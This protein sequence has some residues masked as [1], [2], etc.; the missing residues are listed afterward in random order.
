[1]LGVL[2]EGNPAVASILE[3]GCGTGGHAWHLVNAGCSVTGLDLSEHMVAN[4]RARFAAAPEDVRRR[5]RA[6]KADASGFALEEKFDALIS[7]F[8]VA[9]YQTSNDALLGYFRSA[10]GALPDGGLFLFDF[11]HGP[12]V[13]TDRPREV[14]RV[15][16]DGPVT[17]TRRTHPVMR[18]NENVVEV[19]YAFSV[20]KGGAAAVPDFHEVHRMR[21]L[22][23][24][25]I[26]LLAAQTGFEL[27]GSGKWLKR[28]PLTDADWYGWVVLRAGA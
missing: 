1:M 16:S 20:E 2:R 6:Q 28:E 18:I 19:N 9:S 8:H 4:A 22:F 15:E 14:V 23:L 11:W 10:R 5:F 21:Y 25:E 27:V 3:L 13:L 26:E 24:P 12:G 17:V 7:L